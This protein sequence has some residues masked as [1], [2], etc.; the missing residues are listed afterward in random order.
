M[1]TTTREAASEERRPE[2]AGTPDVTFREQELVNLLAWFI[3]VRWLF[4]VGLGLAI[5]A[6]AR[7][8]HAD[9]PVEKTI[10]VALAIL[11]YNVLL[12]AH[13][14]DLRRRPV[15]LLSTS[16]ME[17]GVQIALDLLALTSLVHLAGGAENPFIG[18]Y[19]FHAIVGSMMLSKAE[20]WGVGIAAFVLFVS[21]VL[22]E[23]AQVLPHYHVSGLWEQS[24][25]RDAPF[26]VVVCL[27]FMVTLFSSMSITSSIVNTLRLRELQLLATQEALVKNSRD[28]ERA[29]ATLTERQ[30]QL[31]QAEKQASLGQLVAGIAHEINN[32]IQFIYGNMGILSEAF[33][34]LL[35]LVDEQT[36]ARP[37]LRIARLDYPFFRKQVPILLKDMADGA[38]R[39]GAIVRDLK[40]FARGDEGRLDEDVDLNEAVQ[41]SLRL[42]HN[43]LRH[44]R[45]EQE[46]HPDLPSV[47]GN[48]TKLEQVVLNTV[49]NAAEA[50][51]RD[52][53]GRIR[54][55]T[56]PEGRGEQV[57]LSIEDNGCGIPPELKDRIFDPFFTT[58]QRSGGTGLGLSI[59]YGIIKQHRG[60]IVVESRVG[61]G[62]AFHFILPASADGAA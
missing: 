13:H 11:F 15:P 49:Q 45:V 62:T 38:A 21:V 48:L 4:L 46:L 23:Y 29:C 37:D 57:R 31:V 52:G 25:H 16:R 44:L 26:L 42:L 5:F 47:R 17:A 19:L 61:A 54:I 9:F 34:D 60:R 12:A 18:F 22:L 24:R 8:F 51:G 35:P 39:I 55:R 50:L 58:K 28:L 20:A 32:P 7:V 36:A 6:G 40:T 53:R 59:T 1:G 30:E 41:A 10:T 3:R 2:G 56:N 14:R 33:S 27:A 43:Q